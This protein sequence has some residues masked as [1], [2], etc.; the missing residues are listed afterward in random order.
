ME[1]SLIDVLIVEDQQLLLGVLRETLD[2]IE[3][4][5]VAA[6]ATTVEKARQVNASYNVSLTDISLPGEIG[7]Q[8]ARE[9]RAN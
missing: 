2:S 1:L 8:F 9:C 7:V 5:T 4:I 6:T 3:G